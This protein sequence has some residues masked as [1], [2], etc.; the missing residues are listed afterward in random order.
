MQAIAEIEQK[1]DSTTPIKFYEEERIKIE[2]KNLLSTKDQ[3]IEKLLQ[4]EK[5]KAGKSPLQIKAKN[6]HD[7]IVKKKEDNSKQQQ[8]YEEIKVHEENFRQFKD[9][10]K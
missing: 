8:E 9:I 1:T 3:L 6:L 4:R 2:R 5:F 7:S 10:F